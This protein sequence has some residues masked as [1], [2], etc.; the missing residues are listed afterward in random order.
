MELQREYF[1]AIIF[2]DFKSN[3]KPDESFNRLRLA[4]IDKSPSRATVYR[5]FNELKR[6]RLTLRDETRSGRPLTAV[7]RKCTGSEKI[8][9]TK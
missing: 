3:L 4:F 5:W 7:T 1:R 9:T 6:G 8:Y 2:Y